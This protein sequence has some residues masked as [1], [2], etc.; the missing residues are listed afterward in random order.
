MFL[1]RVNNTSRTE[2]GSN[3]STSIHCISPRA[4]VA[5]GPRYGA[6]SL[7]TPEATKSAASRLTVSVTF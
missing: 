4:S 2:A 5:T 3:H 7:V 1:G 6:R